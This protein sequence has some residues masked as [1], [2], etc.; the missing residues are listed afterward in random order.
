MTH[1]GGVVLA[2]GSG[3]RLGA[4]KA[5]LVVAG[6][7]LVDSA[8]TALAGGGC[9]PVLAVVR[10]GVAVPGATAVI[11]SDPDRGLRSS[12]ELAI[13]AAATIDAGDG[14]DAVAVLLADL[15]GVSGA[16]VAAVLA[17][18]RPGRIAAASWRGRRGHPIV[19]SPALWREALALAGPDDG[20]RA[21]LAARAELVDDVAVAGATD[22][23]DTPADLARWRDVPG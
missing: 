6:S 1:I 13:D 14:P 12:L 3:T 21:L 4:P 15:P 2:A 17:A 5:E 11:N 10:A 7:R 8:V 16:T 19:M 9:N 20:A 22:D 23:L 18:W